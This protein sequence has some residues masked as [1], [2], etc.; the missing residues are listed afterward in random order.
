[1]NSYVA[2]HI[3]AREDIKITQK[4]H[5][6]CTMAGRCTPYKKIAEC[7]SEEEEEDTAESVS[8]SSS[9][10]EEECNY[11]TEFVPRTDISSW[12]S[13]IQTDF[14][15]PP[16]LLNTP[17]DILA[18]VENTNTKRT[19]TPFTEEAASTIELPTKK[20]KQEKKLTITQDGSGIYASVRISVPPSVDIITLNIVKK[21]LARHTTHAIAQDRTD[22]I[23]LGRAKDLINFDSVTRR[24]YH[25]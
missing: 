7:C 9:E 5:P 23:P 14:P 8:R 24:C 22:V 18:E 12:F 17:T 16:K 19:S 13:S 10:A 1:M 4:I 21:G 6:W 2:K 15:Q 3:H 20:A 25:L 11:T